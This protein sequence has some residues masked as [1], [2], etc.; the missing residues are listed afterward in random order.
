MKNTGLTTCPLH[1]HA[2]G[3]QVKKGLGTART[4]AQLVACLTLT[5]PWDGAPLTLRESRHGGDAWL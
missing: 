5:E 2:L 3:H 4:M 1:S